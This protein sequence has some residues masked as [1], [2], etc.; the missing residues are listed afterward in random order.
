M[1]SPVGQTRGDRAAARVGVKKTGDPVSC[2]A[3]QVE[4]LEHPLGTKAKPLSLQ[5]SRETDEV[6]DDRALAS[7]QEKPTLFKFK[8]AAPGDPPRQ[9]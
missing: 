9:R 7:T 4:L 6:V 1:S 2:R 5:R 8:T 3:L